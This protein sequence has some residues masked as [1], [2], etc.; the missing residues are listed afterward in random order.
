M[1]YYTLPQ[2]KHAH[3]CRLKELPSTRTNP[4]YWE[5]AASINPYIRFTRSRLKPRV[6]SP[7]PTQKP[8]FLPVGAASPSRQIYKQEQSSPPCVTWSP[9][10]VTI[11]HYIP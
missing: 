11:R 1:I 2:L 4:I 9:Q 8:P 5:T 10:L 3:S 7:L 6:L